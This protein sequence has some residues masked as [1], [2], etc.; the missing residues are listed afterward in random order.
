ML[1][2]GANTGKTNA[3]KRYCLNRFDPNPQYLTTISIDYKIKCTNINGLDYKVLIWD[4]VGQERFRNLSTRLYRGGDSFALFYSVADRSSFDKVK[5]FVELVERLNAYTNPSD[6]SKP[7]V[8][9]GAK[10]DL[11][12]NVEDGG[13][14][15]SYKEGSLL[16]KKLNIPFHE[17]SSKDNVNVTE[18]FEHLI[19]IGSGMK[20]CCYKYNLIPWSI[21]NHVECCALQKNV[22]KQILVWNLR[23][24]CL[25]NDLILCIFKLLPIATDDCAWY[26]MTSNWDAY[27]ENKK[28]LLLEK[29][30]ARKKRAKENR[31]PLKKQRQRHHK[32]NMFQKCVVM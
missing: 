22:M 31:L 18:A 9:I 32:S 14:K 1:V 4:T 28:T 17:I 25:P 3:L 10:A 29:E 12:H 6:G 24:S 11:T 7:M 27:I 2:G 13:R 21:K 8:L 23:T 20:K 15:V 5:F 30:K 26:K 19:E 16:A